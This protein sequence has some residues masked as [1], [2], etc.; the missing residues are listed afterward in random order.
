LLK[1][2]DKAISL[3]K[4]LIKKQREIKS[5]IGLGS[6]LTVLSKAYLGKK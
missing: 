6:S 3:I 5:Y 2:Y 1:E 4:P